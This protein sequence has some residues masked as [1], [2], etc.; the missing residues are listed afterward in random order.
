MK[1]TTLTLTILFAASALMYAGPE[2]FS[3][4]EM[5]QVAPAPE[6][7]CF[8]WSGFYVG[9][10]GGYKFTVV[11]HNLSLGGLWNGDIA[12]DSELVESA[13]SRDL[14]TSGGELGGLVGYNWQWNCWVLGLEA[15]GGYLW[16]RDS[17]DSGTI[18]NTTNI[19]PFHVRNAFQTHYLF[20]FGP[21][22]GYAFG[23]W[24]PYITGGLAVG[25][26]EF[27]QAIAFP[28]EA[29]DN[30]EGGRHTETN[31]GWMVGGGLQYALTDHWSLRAQYQYIDLGDIDFT[32]NFADTTAFPAHSHAELREHNVSFAIMYKF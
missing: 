20:T 21:R 13:G 6:S 23:R 31:V 15:D 1:K 30:V 5:K 11:D 16:A 18:F 26:L 25:D 28:D 10:F 9:G 2:A 19:D 14:N 12:S 32:S 4:K 22:I 29:P 24:L 3:G 17:R 27:E 8:N 7:A